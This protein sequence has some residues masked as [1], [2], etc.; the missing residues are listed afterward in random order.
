MR[1]LRKRKHVS[2][3]L[4]ERNQNDDRCCHRQNTL[5]DQN[6]TAD[7]T[8]GGTVGAEVVRR[9]ENAHDRRH[10]GDDTDTDQASEQNT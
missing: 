2:T 10:G 8:K 6:D 3:Y 1:C 7:D 5:R 9:A 4:R